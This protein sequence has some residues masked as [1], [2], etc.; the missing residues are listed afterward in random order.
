VH[1]VGFLI[2]RSSANFANRLDAFRS[3]MRELGYT[4]GKDLVIEWRFADGH[5]DRLP[6]LARELVQ[7]RVDVIVADSTPGVQAVRGATASIP[8]V[9]LSVGDPVASGFVKSLS[10]PGGNVTG[11]SNVTADVSSKYVELL[12][13]AM[14]G[15]AR[16]A[17]LVNPD[18][19]NHPGIASQVLAA[20][21]AKGMSASTVS[22]RTPAEI[23]VVFAGL[24]KDG[25]GALVVMGDP[26][27][28]QQARQFAELTLKYRVP[29]LAT[30]RGLAE[31][32]G[33][34]SYGQDLVEHYRRAA[35]YVDKLLKGA[36]AA[37]LPVE[38]S[39][40]IELVV[41]LRTA[42]ALGLVIPTPLLLRADHVVQ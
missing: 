29:T 34:L 33:L 23:D 2:P 21:K 5:Y 9:M 8:V 31:A 25:V 32:G 27:Y 40:K 1:R 36:S 24:R 30:N 16:I 10:R 4:E 38:Q 13:E 14:P 3:G 7:S 18:N 42:K 12:R 20:A 41:N 19:P 6:T 35:S 39:T 28:G 26:F 22:A 11:L 37:D 15:L 17:V